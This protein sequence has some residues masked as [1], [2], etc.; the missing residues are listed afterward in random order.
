MPDDA[1]AAERSA[2]EMPDWMERYRGL[3]E[4]DLGGI[5]TEDLLNDTTTTG[6]D[7][8][9]R[10]ALICTADSKVRMLYALRRYGMLRYA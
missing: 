1:M 4:A 2:W 3:I 5:C 7:H 6:R 10:A 9:I 8:V